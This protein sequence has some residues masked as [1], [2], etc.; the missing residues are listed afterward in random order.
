MK[1]SVLIEG[2]EEGPVGSF[3]LDGGASARRCAR[4]NGKSRRHRNANREDEEEDIQ[5]TEFIQ[6]LPLPAR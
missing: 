4:G 6:D 1:V 3:D 5:Q 2:V